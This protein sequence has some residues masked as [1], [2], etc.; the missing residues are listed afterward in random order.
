MPRA[1]PA[2]ASTTVRAARIRFAP[3]PMWS[4]RCRSPACGGRGPSAARRP[5]PRRPP[6]WRRCGGRATPEAPPARC[7]GGDDGGPAGYGEKPFARDGL[8]GDPPAL[9]LRTPRRSAS[10]RVSGIGR[11]VWSVTSCS[12]SMPRQRY[13]VAHRS[14]GPHTGP[15]TGYA[16]LPVRLPQH[17]P[18]LHPAAREQH[19]V[20]VVPVVAAGVLVDARRAAELAHH[21]HQRPLQHAAL[22]QVVE[23]RRHGRGRTAAAACRAAGGSCPCACPRRPAASCR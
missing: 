17:P 19:R 22:R 11:P 1:S 13:T 23:Q 2:S 6:P 9:R 21:H 18:R 16:P 20:A 10:P 5:P 15:R 12:G 14:P 3:S 8:R 4:P 7:A